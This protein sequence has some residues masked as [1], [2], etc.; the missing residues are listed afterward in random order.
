MKKQNEI[1][2]E[3][4]LHSQKGNIP[5]QHE[6]ARF[7]LHKNSIH[8]VGFTRKNVVMNP[9]DRDKWIKVLSESISFAS[10]EN[11]TISI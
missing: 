5:S 11:P 6:I 9:D 2:Y 8:R 3:W 1:T 10:Q 7:L 4:I